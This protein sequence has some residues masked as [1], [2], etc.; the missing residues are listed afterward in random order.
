MAA[1][2][3]VS[4]AD[5]AFPSLP[6]QSVFTFCP[7]GT[8]L[9]YCLRL[10]QRAKAKHP[11]AAP[12]FGFSLCHLHSSGQSYFCSLCRPWRVPHFHAHRQWTWRISL[13]F[14]AETPA[15]SDFFIFLAHCHLPC[16]QIMAIFEKNIDKIRKICKKTLFKQKKIGYNKKTAARQN[17]RTGGKD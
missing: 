2:C 1:S 7:A 12:C 17:F 3:T 4:S 5:G 15:F 10:H 13:F 8:G 9:W 14:S 16:P 11:W 6:R